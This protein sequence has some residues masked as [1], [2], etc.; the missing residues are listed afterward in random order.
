MA[1]FRRPSPGG[2]ST[3]RVPDF[4]GDSGQVRYAESI[5]IG[6]RWYDTRRL[7]VLFPFGHGLSYTSFKVG[8]PVLASASVPVGTLVTVALPV[9]N[10]GD[11]R[12]QPPSCSATSDRTRRDWSAPT[13]S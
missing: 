6:Y 2:S 10:T 13:R 11:R 4:P 12:G 3:P 9:T 8:S 5:L 1:G 7:P